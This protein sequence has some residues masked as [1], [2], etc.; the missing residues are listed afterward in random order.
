MNHP[1]LS[2]SDPVTPVM[3]LS[4]IQF[5]CNTLPGAV[6]GIM[7]SSKN[8]NEVVNHSVMMRE[9]T[10]FPHIQIMNFVLLSKG[11]SDNNCGPLFLRLYVQDCIYGVRM[12]RVEDALYLILK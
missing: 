9:L 8:M 6:S 2:L 10:A 11:K 1:T 5:S 12:T 7:C 4:T 3:A